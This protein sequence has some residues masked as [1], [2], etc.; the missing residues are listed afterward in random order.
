[1]HVWGKKRDSLELNDVE[2]FHIDMLSMLQDRQMKFD[3]ILVNIAMDDIDDTDL[4]NLLKEQIGRVI[5]NKNVEYKV[6]QNNPKFGEFVTFKPYVFDRIG[7]DVDVFY[8]HFKGYSTYSIV[9]RKSFPERVVRY[10]E[11]YWSY[12][13]YRYSLNMSDVQKN[14]KDNCTYFWAALKCKEDELS[15]SYCKAY[16]DK[17]LKT[18]PELSK[19]IPGDTLIHSPG[20]FGWYNL[21]NIGEVLKDKPE[22]INV[23]AELLLKYDEGCS[24]MCTHFCELYLTLFLDENKCYYFNDYSDD[25]KK[26][27]VPL[28]I[29]AYASKKFGR[30]L[31]RD[32]EKYLMDVGLI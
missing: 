31:L 22:V 23:D 9:K 20:S 15:A 18:I 19:Y 4:F 13:M 21:K 1:M 16:K 25:I 17:L 2:K 30:E 8:S 3:K 27:N 14:L 10:N 6:C 7:E 28:Y 11:M 12:I 32:F 5:I 24:N 29:T 26:T